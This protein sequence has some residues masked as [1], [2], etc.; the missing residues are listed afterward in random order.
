MT[1][2]KASY[3]FT[4]NVS[5]NIVMFIDTDNSK[6]L[7]TELL[8]HKKISSWIITNRIQLECGQCSSLQAW[9][10]TMLFNNPI[11]IKQISTIISLYSEFSWAVKTI[12]LST[13]SLRK[14]N[15]LIMT[16]K[17]KFSWVHSS[18]SRLLKSLRIDTE[19]KK[20]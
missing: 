14:T 13:S 6:N 18:P 11:V 15:L 1:K 5:V 12:H 10:T 8:T 20:C 4:L 7:Y 9:I 3:Q 2:S 19:M 16:L 17:K